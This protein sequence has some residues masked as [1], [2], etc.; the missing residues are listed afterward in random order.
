MA[1]SIG[2]IPVTEQ[3]RAV[4]TSALRVLEALG[5]PV[6]VTEFDLGAR[7]FLATGEVLPQDELAALRTMDALVV[8]SPPV[9]ADGIPRGVLERGIIF[10]LRAELDLYV[11]LRRYTGDGPVDVAVVRENTEGGY[12]GEG[13]VLRPG[14]RDAVATQGSVTTAFGVERCLRYAFELARRRR[15]KL[16]LVHKASVLEYSG[17]VWTST[18]AS[19]ST[20]Y[21]DVDY[22]YVDVD[23]ACVQLIE[24]ASRFDVIVTDN[25]FGDI[26]TDVAGAVTGS[27]HRSGSADLN[28]SGR[29]PS[30]FEPLHASAARV[31]ATPV[32]R[33]DP[34]GAHAAMALLLD[35]FGHEGDASRLHLAVGSVLDDDAR[36]LAD[37]E[38]AVLALCRMPSAQ[39]SWEA[40]S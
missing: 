30:L 12:I 24:D 20:M 17:S 10:R 36:T 35:H 38:A 8:G 16:T 4:G 18:L 34:R 13:G 23:T 3:G 40:P 2:L 25:L 22:T 39:A 32:E 9:G 14:T 7:R 11:N 26:V 15:K 37:T 29:G 1:W 5:H 21:D 33:A 19:L 27:L 6:D 31:S 28:A